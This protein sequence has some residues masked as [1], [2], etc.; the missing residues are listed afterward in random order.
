MLAGR[1]SGAQ[2]VVQARYL[3]AADGAASPIRQQLGVQLDGPTGPVGEGGG[4][5]APSM[6][7]EDH[8]SVDASAAVTN[9]S[10]HREPADRLALKRSDVAAGDGAV[11]A[12][13]VPRLERL[14]L[15]DVDVGPV[16]DQAAPIGQMRASDDRL[17][18]EATQWTLA[19]PFASNRLAATRQVAEQ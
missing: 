11:S 9:L 12:Q 10:D 7:R 8:Q 17:A 19:G 3:I 2:H 16:D 14:V 18:R 5:A 13:V 6:R 15:A 4:D 1:R